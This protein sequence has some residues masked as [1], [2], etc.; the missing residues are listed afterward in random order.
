MDVN[1]IELIQN[2]TKS[3]VYNRLSEENGKQF[4]MKY[5]SSLTH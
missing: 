3:F 1:E 4:D 5:F 2:T